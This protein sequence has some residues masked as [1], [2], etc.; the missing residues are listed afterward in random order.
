MIE[1]SDL[2][3]L[4]AVCDDKTNKRAFA[5]N[6]VAEANALERVLKQTGLD[7]D[8][9]IL[10]RER[11]FLVNEA[12]RRGKMHC[13]VARGQYILTIVAK[14]EDHDRTTKDV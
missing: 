1:L 12:L 5:A 2:A 10:P 11:R 8:W 4:R 13:N 3:F 7:F 14:E 9:P 6:D